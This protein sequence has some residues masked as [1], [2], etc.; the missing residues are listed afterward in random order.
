MLQDQF[1]VN[2]SMVLQTSL[3][4][5]CLLQPITSRTESGELSACINKHQ[6]FPQVFKAPHQQSSLISDS[7]TDENKPP[8]PF[9]AS[10]MPASLTDRV[11]HQAKSRISRVKVV[12]KAAANTSSM[13]SASLDFDRLSKPMRD[14][15]H[16]ALKPSC[17]KGIT[18]AFQLSWP[19]PAAMASSVGVAPANQ[20]PSSL[21]GVHC[22]PLLPN[23]S[24]LFLQNC[25]FD[26]ASMLVSFVCAI[27]VC[28]N[29]GFKHLASACSTLMSLSVLKP[30]ALQ[31][32]H[33]AVQ[34]WLRLSSH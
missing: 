31:H 19:P 27:S 26:Y 33:L 2:G 11:R 25:E 32:M 28:A 10:S 9:N 30:T 13:Q 14:P 34:R 6:P 8:L 24:T 7:E 29:L 16:N 18:S 5:E 12:R 3:S 21:T 20:Y 22:V 23:S 17:A 15:G 1:A 4:A